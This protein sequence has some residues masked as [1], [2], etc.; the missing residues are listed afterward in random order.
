M[1]MFTVFLSFDFLIFFLFY[2]IFFLQN[3]VEAPAYLRTP[4]YAPGCPYI[5]Y[6]HTTFGITNTL[7]QFKQRK[8]GQ[9]IDILKCFW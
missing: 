3:D 1:Y 7:R 2:S 6:V 8:F 4:G 9:G 5:K